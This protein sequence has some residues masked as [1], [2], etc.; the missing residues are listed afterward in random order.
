MK[1]EYIYRANEGEIKNHVLFGPAR[2]IDWYWDKVLLVNFF[3][4]RNLRT[5][6]LKDSV[7]NAL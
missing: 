3:P 6:S 4:L 5:V 1:T 2:N 7:R